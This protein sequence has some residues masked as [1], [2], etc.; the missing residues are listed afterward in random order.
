MREHKYRGKRVDNG[1]WVFG[2]L[3]I[4]NQLTIGVFICPTTTMVDFA[5][6]FA[7]GDNVEKVKENLKDYGCALGGFFEVDPKTVGKYIGLKDKNGKEIYEGDCLKD[8]DGGFI[9][10]NVSIGEVDLGKDDYGLKYRSIC[11]HAAY[12]DGSGFLALLDDDSNAYGK[13]TSHCEIIGNVHDNPELLTS[14]NDTQK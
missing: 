12:R 9:Y 13:S 3:F 7:D 14:V 4:P 8:D 1:E 5:P 2:N 6:G 11:A 10:N